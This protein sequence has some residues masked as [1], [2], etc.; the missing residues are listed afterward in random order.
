MNWVRTWLT[1][2]FYFVIFVLFYFSFAVD[3][4]LPVCVSRLS[5]IY[6]WLCVSVAH[7][8]RQID[9]CKCA[10]QPSINQTLL[11]LLL[12]HRNFPLGSNEGLSYVLSYLRSCSVFTVQ[13]SWLAN[14]AN[15]IA[16][17]KPVFDSRWHFHKDWWHN[18]CLPWYW[19]G[20]KKSQCV[21]RTL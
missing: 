4:L 2:V 13:H 18:N 19:Y 5:M 17:L 6:T 15:H 1:L 3:T 21:Q 20:L 16:P 14:I 11:L 10:M 8:K 7:I 12:W 9:Y